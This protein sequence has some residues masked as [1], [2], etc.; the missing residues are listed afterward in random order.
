VTNDKR[1]GRAGLLLR[2]STGPGCSYL[3]AVTFFCVDVTIAVRV[4]F[5]ARKLR[6]YG[7]S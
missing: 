2:R 6:C 1:F 7:R 3:M 5:V 4:F